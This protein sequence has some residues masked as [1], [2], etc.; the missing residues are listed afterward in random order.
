MTVDGVRLPLLPLKTSRYAN[1]APRNCSAGMVADL[2]SMDE[3]PRPPSIRGQSLP[4][5]DA[6]VVQFSSPSTG[7]VRYP[8]PAVTQY[9]PGT[10]R[11]GPARTSRP[12]R[13]F[14]AKPA[15]RPG[16]PEQEAAP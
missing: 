8:H 15:V 12:G 3:E 9:G 4:D 7:G 11:L 10:D 2:A 14:Q 6:A 5:S 16:N 13:V 1:P